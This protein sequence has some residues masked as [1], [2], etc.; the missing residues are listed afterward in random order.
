ME[1]DSHDLKIFEKY[2]AF[3][4]DLFVSLGRYNTILI[5]KEFYE[6]VIYKEMGN[7]EK[8]WKGKTLHGMKILKVDQENFPNYMFINLEK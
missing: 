3:Q 1:I 6:N 4:H 8:Y 5:K 2:E 7:I